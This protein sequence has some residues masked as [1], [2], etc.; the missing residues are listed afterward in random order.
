MF[1]DCK[2]TNTKVCE[3][4]QDNGFVPFQDIT[5]DSKGSYH[6]MVMLLHEWDNRPVDFLYRRSTQTFHMKYCYPA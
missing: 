1:L 5:L 2:A 4:Y 3:L 6:Q